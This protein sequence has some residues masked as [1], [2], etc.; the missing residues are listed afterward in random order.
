MKGHLA[1]ILAIFGLWALALS[2]GAWAAPSDFD[3]IATDPTFQSWVEQEKLN[4]N[5]DVGAVEHLAEQLSWGEAKAINSVGGVAYIEVTLGCPHK[6]IGCLARCD[7]RPGMKKMSWEQ[8]EQSTKGIAGLQRALDSVTPKQFQ[9]ISP[10][11]FGLYFGND[12]MN[13]RLPTSNGQWKGPRELMRYSYEKT[14]IPT[15]VLTAGWVPTDPVLE[16]EARQIAEDLAAGTAPYIRTFRIEVKPITKPFLQDVT[17]IMK[18]ILAR[19]PE[20]MK[21]FSDD[22]SLHGLSFEKYSNRKKALKAY[23]SLVDKH[24]NEIITGS[25]YMQDRIANL[26][27]FLPALKNDK[28]NAQVIFYGFTHDTFWPSGSGGNS[29]GDIIPEILFP[30]SD[31]SKLGRVINKQHLDGQLNLGKAIFGHWRD[32]THGKTVQRGSSPQ[33]AVIKENGSIAIDTL[34]ANRYFMTQAKDPHI[35]TLAHR[36]VLFSDGRP[37]WQ[38]ARDRLDTTVEP[39]LSERE[40][41]SIKVQ[42]RKAAPELSSR[43]ILLNNQVDYQTVNGKPHVPVVQVQI[44]SETKL[45]E[46]SAGTLI[47]DLSNAGVVAPVK[48]RGCLTRFLDLLIR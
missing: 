42:I 2:H 19:D 39:F 26:K 35:R 1:S 6:C 7:I 41:E 38:F 31:S 3:R 30:F 25:K 43:P 37:A 15:D 12:P 4:G 46:F 13:N 44:E 48:Q 36:P 11:Y 27:L 16:T 28:T 22:F 24:Y 45:F 23:Y 34:S 10:K 17:R 29:A 40:L 9:L 33:A 8:F 18:N 21:A 47:P 32:V 14:G 5:P 20:F